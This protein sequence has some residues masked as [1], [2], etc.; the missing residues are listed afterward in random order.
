MNI[1]NP[2]RTEILSVKSDLSLPAIPNPAFTETDADS[3]HEGH[4]PI[5]VSTFEMKVNRLHAND[6][7]MFS[8]EYDVSWQCYVACVSMFWS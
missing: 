3:G 5:P 6:N 4:P 7:Y 1:Q 2:N 8:Q